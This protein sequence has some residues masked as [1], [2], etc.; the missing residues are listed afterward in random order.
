[1]KVPCAV[2]FLENNPGNN[3]F[4]PVRV[5]CVTPQTVLLEGMLQCKH[6]PYRPFLSV[7]VAGG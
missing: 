5:I 7:I 1:M 3:H 2:M 4:K 6:Y